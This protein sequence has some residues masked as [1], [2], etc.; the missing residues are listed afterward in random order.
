MIC[1]NCTHSIIRTFANGSFVEHEVFCDL[2]GMRLIKNVS[3]CSRMSGVVL[4]E[5]PTEIRLPE[6]VLPKECLHHATL[7]A[8]GTLRDGKCV[9]CNEYVP[10]LKKRG[11]PNWRKRGT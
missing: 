2:D 8:G 4:V 3:E 6:P 5:V 9:V 1:I 7:E 11:N 10:P